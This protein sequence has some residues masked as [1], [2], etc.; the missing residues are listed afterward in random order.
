[1]SWSTSNRRAERQNEPVRGCLV[2]VIGGQPSRT[3]VKHRKADASGELVLSSEAQSAQEDAYV[4]VTTWPKCLL[5]LPKEICR[6]PPKRK[7]AKR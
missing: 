4:L 3:K 7:F 6:I 2:E 5:R 1:M